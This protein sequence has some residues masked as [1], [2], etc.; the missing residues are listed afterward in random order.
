MCTRPALRAPPLRLPALRA[1]PPLMLMMRPQPAVFMNGMTAREQR[2]APTYLTLKSSIKSSSMTVSIGPVAVAEPPGADPL[3]TRICRPPSCCAASATMRS[4]CSLL[5]T[6]AARGTMRRFVSAANSRAVASRSALFRATIATSAPSRANSRAMALP[7][8]R[9]PPVTIAC[10]SCNPRSMAF[11]PL[12]EWRDSVVPRPLFSPR[13]PGARRRAWMV[14]DR[15]PETTRFRAASDRQ[16][17][18]IHGYGAAGYPARLVGGE[19]QHRHNEIVGLAEPA[20]RNQRLCRTPCF[21][22]GIA[23]SR[24]PGQRWA[25]GN[26]VDADAVRRQI[27]GH[28]VGQRAGAALRSDIGGALGPRHLGELRGHVDDAAAALLHHLPR[29]CLS[30]VKHARQVDRDDAVPSLGIDIQ[31]IE[32]VADP[33]RF[34]HDIKPPEFAHHRGN[35]PIDRHPVAHVESRHTCPPAGSANPG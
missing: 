4:T 13:N 1:L 29:R 2:S 33:G 26:R 28:R 34:E 21:R 5:V 19:K 25:G 12:L 16:I 14:D 3:F 9:L 22:I 31:E 18:A 20:E 11:S 23:R 35:H 10:L 32:P 8:P 15:R 27:D 7:M 30:D 17:A 6:S 24:Q